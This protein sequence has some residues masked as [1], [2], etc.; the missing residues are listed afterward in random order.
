MTGQAVSHPPEGAIS[1]PTSQRTG[2]LPGLAA[3]CLILLAYALTFS[4][5]YDDA[6]DTARWMKTGNIQAMFE[7]RHLI[8]RLMPFWFWCSLRASGMHI[9]ALSALQMTDFVSAA[10]TVI[11]MFALLRKLEVTLGVAIATTFALA[12]AW[13]FWMYA[14]T[15]RPYST[16]LGL[17]VAAYLV[18]ASMDEELSERARLLR[19]FS[20]GALVLFSCLFWLQQF[21]NCLGVGLLVTLRP[22]R[23]TV[24]QR[25]SCL[26]VYAATGLIIGFLVLL[27]GLHYI[28]IVPTPA[29][30]HE[31]IV[32]TNTAPVKFDASSIMKAAY[33][34]AAGIIKIETLPYMIN[35]LL[36]HDPR[37][38]AVGSLPRQMSRFVVA[39][40]L[41]APLYLYP[42]LA[43]PRAAP[44]RR[45]LLVAF[46]LPLA[47]NM[48][49]ALAWLGSD[50]QRFQPSLVS[51]G[52]LGAFAVT[53]LLEYLRN[54]I[55]WR[56]LAVATI[57]SLL[58]FVSGVN[59][60]D[61]VL[62]EQR[63]FT[64]LADEMKQVRGAADTRDFVVFFGRDLSVTYHTMLTYYL[65]P[66]YVDL[67]DE[68]FFHWESPNW[69]HQLASR[70]DPVLARHGRVFV[71][72]RLA[73]GVNPISAAWSEVQRPHPT[74]REIGAFLHAK[75]C[76]K[77]AW[78]IGPNVYWQV[79]RRTD[80]CNVGISGAGG[81]SA[82]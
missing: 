16:A 20:T 50:Q 9:G 34:Q 79:E 53:S 56:R 63:E 27:S 25:C 36:R 45:A 54:N 65:G 81:D 13:A 6:L 59:L 58:A 46:F 80:P 3:F 26:G 35:G 75:Y 29:A 52:V 69:A 30:I 8:S 42:I 60:F 67:G 82:L 7:F 14:G 72:D 70:I 24:W 41:V 43:F 28:G 78:K 74:V 47:V 17:S 19:A 18:A 64:A 31:W 10:A 12:T 1:L 51:L 21:T 49:F 77:P 48:G 37:M 40:V 76:L 15:G 33:G 11:L 57:L 62:R 66:S 2:V 68:T 44:K 39:W 4:H 23:R 71:V 38:L 5:H 61:G 55:R 22:H 32:G 73:L